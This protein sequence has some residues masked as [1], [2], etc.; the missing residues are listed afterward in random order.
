MLLIAFFGVH[1]SLLA[2]AQ[3]D[4]KES[5]TKS[6]VYIL[7]SAYY[8][9]DEFQNKGNAFGL[10]YDLTWTL[11]NNW[12]FGLRVN[13]RNWSGRDET[14]V[15]LEIGP[16]YT[17]SLSDRTSM[18]TFLG[19]G[20]SLIMGNDYAGFFAHLS[21]G[22]RLNYEVG[23]VAMFTGASDSKAAAYH[24]DSFE[25]IDIMFGIRF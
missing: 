20:P 4:S 19:A 10:G 9:D 3:S 6:H 18:D 8:D 15:P 25:H 24:P 1:D 23:S 14:L 17:F 16:S 11:K 22:F 21:G 12:S 13:Y 7:S 5:K 2:Q